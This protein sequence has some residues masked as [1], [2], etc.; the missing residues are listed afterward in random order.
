MVKVFDHDKGSSPGFADFIRERLPKDPVES[1]FRQETG[2]TVSLDFRKDIGAHFLRVGCEIFSRDGN[3]WL[4]LRI[5][6]SWG[7]VGFS[8]IAFVRKA[9]VGSALPALISYDPDLP[10]QP[11][12][13]SAIY[14]WSPLD[15]ALLPSGLFVRTEL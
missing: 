1:G 5:E 4:R 14:L 8:D 13:D 3:R 9:F 10:D 2:S 11:L 6:K 15:R 7:P 12:G